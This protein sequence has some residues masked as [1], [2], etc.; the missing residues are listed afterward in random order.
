[1]K[2]LKELKS[3]ADQLHKYFS[4]TVNRDPTWKIVA[5]SYLTN[6]R[7]FNREKYSLRRIQLYLTTRMAESSQIFNQ[8]GLTREIK[9]A[10]A[11][12]VVFT[13]AM[14]EAMR[15]IFG[16]PLDD[17]V[18]NLAQVVFESENVTVDQVKKARKTAE[19]RRGVH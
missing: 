8:L 7:R 5:G 2:H 6:T 9:T 13:A 15:N 11:P 17:V 10:I 19:R 3:C 4:D 12:R 1:M 18:C 16:R 14:S